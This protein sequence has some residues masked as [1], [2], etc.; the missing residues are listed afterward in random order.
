M[1]FQ[2][3]AAHAG[4]SYGE[5]T[6]GGLRRLRRQGG[7]ADRWY[8]GDPG[9]G[10]VTVTWNADPNVKYW[11]V[12]APGNSISTTDF[13]TIPGA[14]AIMNVTSPMFLTGL[15][16]GYPYSFAMNGRTGDNPVVQGTGRGHC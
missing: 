11:F 9:D 4:R 7:C 5:L 6:G 3:T 10:K 13:I 15:V 14:R 16:N 12:Y 8:H 2:C 1:K